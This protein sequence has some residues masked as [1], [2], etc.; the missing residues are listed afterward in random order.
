MSSQLPP[1]R[2]TGGRILRDG[3]LQFRSV[4][5][6]HGRISKGPLP[7][8][9][10]SGYLILP[11]VIDMWAM[12]SRAPHW[13][14]QSKWHLVQADR[15]G[16]TNGVTLQYLC[17]GWSWEGPQASPETA[18]AMA[19]ALQEQRRHLATDLRLGL[20]I[21][22][23]MSFDPARILALVQTYGIDL[24]MFSNRAE[25]ARGLAET[26]RIAFGNLARSLG[27]DP[28]TL[29]LLLEGLDANAAA[30]PRSL[31]TLAEEFDALGITYGSME[32]ETGEAREHHSMLG[33][34]VCM[35][36][37]NQ[38]AAAA[39]RAVSDPVIVSAAD[40]GD[41]IRTQTLS[42]FDLVG[43]D[44]LVSGGSAM[45][46]AELA[47]YISETGILPLPQA[48]ALVSEHPARLLRLTDR[49][50]LDLG[51]HADLTIVNEQSLQ[52][53]AT[54]SR[55]RLAYLSGEAGA[56]FFDRRVDSAVAAE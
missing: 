36:P 46:L 7:A 56:R 19:V 42:Q 8:V 23:A 50:R 35:T 22:H 33:A 30:I 48:W 1:L 9:D 14:E 40:L 6:S 31:C 38:R 54:I 18:Q 41:R 17:Q 16:A 45:S 44:A 5:V 24:V 47:L 4:A 3:N 15:L 25:R 13:W 39:A 21:D 51:C 49:G 10:L 55:G 27:Q 32:D 34:G 20:Q 53:E 52:I 12:P 11:G 28:S 29:R 2:F 43:I 26:D 37:R